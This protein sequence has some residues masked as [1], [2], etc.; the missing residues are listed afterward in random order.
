MFPSYLVVELLNLAP[1]GVHVLRL[2]FL[3]GKLQETQNWC[4]VTDDQFV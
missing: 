4:P 1:L 2:E 3:E